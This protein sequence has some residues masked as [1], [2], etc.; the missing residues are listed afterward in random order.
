M[1]FSSLAKAA[2]SVH[3]SF[4]FTTT[5]TPEFGRVSSLSLCLE[6]STCY[7]TLQGLLVYTASKQVA[8]FPSVQ[9]FKK[10]RRGANQA[11]HLDTG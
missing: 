2:G 4:E 3:D 9:L 5:H 10:K 6:G 1:W 7:S 8:A 11:T